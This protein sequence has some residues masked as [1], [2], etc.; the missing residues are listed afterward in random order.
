MKPARIAVLLASS[1]FLAACAYVPHK[2]GET[3][4]V[5][6]DYTASDNAKDA[7][8]YVYG[9]RTLLEFEGTPT[10]LMVKDESGASVDYER[11]GRYYRLA[12]RLDD[13]TVWVNGRAVT[14]SAATITRVFSAPAPA[15]A[16]VAHQV[17]AVKLSG[18]A[19]VSQGDV[20]VVALLDLS[21]KQLQAVHQVVD[22]NEKNPKATGAELFS[23]NSRLNEMAAA[24][25]LQVT[26]PTSSTAFK[27][28]S[29]VATILI[30]SAKAAESINLHGYTDSKVAGRLDEKIAR[31]RAEAARKFLAD[32]GVN[33]DKIK[34]FS[35]AD[36]GFV[37]P[38]ITKE[39][40]SLNR[41]VEVEFVN[42]RIAQVKG[43]TVKLA[44]DKST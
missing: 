3:L 18:Q 39:G 40:K 33:A 12:R 15:P 6:P 36:G 34:V 24:A 30:A 4:R 13:F 20:D 31:G 43:R 8:A 2:D 26:F 22:M 23:A 10:V 38:N 44:A 16:A 1:A 37:A 19:P 9:D 27:P 35:Q 42:P 11:V 21:A 28:S 25:I 17:N 29:D 7:R 14:F 5:S 32:A 41:R